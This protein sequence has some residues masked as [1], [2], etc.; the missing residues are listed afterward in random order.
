M[1]QATPG[2]SG[3]PGG[4]VELLEEV[5]GRQLHLLVPPLGGAVDAGDEKA[6][7]R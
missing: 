7:L 5:V 4:P 6:S 2:A 3:D 1:S